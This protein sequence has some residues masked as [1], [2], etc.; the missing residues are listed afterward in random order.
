[1][2]PVHKV[3]IMSQLMIEE[4]PEEEATGEVVVTEE[5]AVVGEPVAEAMMDEDTT[6]QE[7]PVAKL[8]PSVE[9]TRMTPRDTM[10]ELLGIQLDRTIQGYLKPSLVEI[11]W[12]NL[13]ETHRLYESLDWQERLE[14][15]MIH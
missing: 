15:M 12:Q 8:G 1:M 7:P 11:T 6:I 5:V 13:Q 4:E 9:V 2:G 14:W 10:E 3:R